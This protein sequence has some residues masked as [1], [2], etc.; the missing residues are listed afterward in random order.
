MSRSMPSGSPPCPCTSSSTCWRTNRTCGTRRATPQKGRPAH[1]FKGFTMRIA[2]AVLLAGLA[3]PALAQDY[4]K[5]KAGLWEMDRTGGGPA[6]Q[7]NRMTMC[8]DDTV[9]KEMFDMGAG[10]MQGMCSKHEFKLSGSGGTGDFICDIGGSPMH[11]NSTRA[12]TGNTGFRHESHTTSHPPFMGQKET[13]TVLTA[14]H[15]GACKAGQ[16]PGDMVLPN[17]Q[18]LN[19]RDAMGAG[20]GAPPRPRAPAAETPKTDRQPG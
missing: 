14:R 1:S 17:G 18:T 20:K 8:L 16:R 4:P 13:A 5:L 19:M 12:L 11:S 9:Q 2:L 6:P 3:L 15:V 10:A 7:M